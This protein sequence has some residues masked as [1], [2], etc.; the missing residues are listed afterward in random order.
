MRIFGNKRDDGE[1]RGI[2]WVF[3]N[4]S[5]VLTAYFGWT[6]GADILVLGII[7]ALLFGAISRAAPLLTKYAAEYFA[8]GSPRVA[9]ICAAFAGLFFCADVLTNFGSAAAIRE[10]EMVTASNR[11]ATAKDIR[12]EVSRLE[13]RISAIQQQTS[14]KTD[15]LAPS[16]Y[17]ALIASA[18]LAR[19]NE[20]KRKYCGR[21]CEA[22]TAE[23][24]ELQA[25]KA[26]AER[27][28]ALKAEMVQL[29]K[30]LVEAKLKAAN[31]QTVASAALS[32]VKNLAGLLT[33]SIAPDE[34]SKTWTNNGIM[35]VAAVI[36]SLG[37]VL[38]SMVL[39]F[40]AGSRRQEWEAQE[41]DHHAPTAD[42]RWLPD[43]R[44]PEE[45]QADPAWDSGP[46]VPLKPSSG[47]SQST[48]TINATIDRG[49]KPN[50]Y[51]V[52]HVDQMLAEI[53]LVLDRNEREARAAA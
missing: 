51:T 46:T 42:N 26:N 30:E 21:K 28:L 11:N 40:R 4:G 22:K 2:N 48:T 24:A 14:W 53:E 34:F 8:T 20:A 52:S 39:G 44:P 18:T 15:Y 17:D 1:L 36:I 43:Q 35:V 6:L 9:G 49:G 31:T 19:D 32:Q 47:S 13:K 29:E 33:L 16:A 27:R 50:P 37:S 45:R 10:Q 25:N 12:G 38:T 7:L 5:M 3:V 23:L 41:A